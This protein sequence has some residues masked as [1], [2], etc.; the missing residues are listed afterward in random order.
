MRYLS[1]EFALISAVIFTTVSNYFLLLQKGGG[2][3]IYRLKSASDIFSS[4]RESLL[5]CDSRAYFRRVGEVDMLNLLRL[6]EH[7]IE[8]KLS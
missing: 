3:P 4:Q 1:G 7:T 2:K 8:L 5:Y 6:S